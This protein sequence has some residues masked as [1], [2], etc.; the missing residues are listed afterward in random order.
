MQY[1]DPEAEER[2]D[3]G[4][5]K[6]KKKDEFIESDSD[7]VKTKAK[8][9]KKAERMSSL[10][11]L[12]HEKSCTDKSPIAGPLLNMNVSIVTAC[13]ISTNLTPSGFSGIES[14]LTRL[15]SSRTKGLVSSCYYGMI[16][17][18]DALP[19]Q[20]FRALLPI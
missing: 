1:P 3:T 10:T 14:C 7:D 4:K 15:S 11:R 2:R 13:Q 9:K 16:Q 5:K 12:M 6:K 20:G 19:F 8:K 18:E 17:S